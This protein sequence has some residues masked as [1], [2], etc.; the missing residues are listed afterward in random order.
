MALV[1]GAEVLVRAGARLAERLG[2]PQI[3]I[4]LTVISIGTSLP[5]LAIGMLQGLA[6]RMRTIVS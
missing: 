3:V 1:V 2:V 4:G 5:E 6:R